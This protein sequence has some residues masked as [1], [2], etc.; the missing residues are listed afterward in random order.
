[1]SNPAVQT[2][3]S[4]PDPSDAP[5]NLIQL[6]QLQNR[7]L[8]SE[9]LGDYTPYVIQNGEPGVA[10]HDKVWFELDA[11]GR[12]V[13]I[14]IQWH[15]SWRRIYN[16][17]MGEIRGYTGNPGNDFDATGWGKPTE[18]YDGWHLCNGNDGAPDYS[19]HFLIGGHMNNEDHSGYIDNEWVT[20]IGKK[21]GMHTGGDI[22]F[23]LTEDTTWRQVIQGEPIDHW[24]DDT[25]TRDPVL[26]KL[27]G[28]PDD[29]HDFLI[30]A[31][32]GNTDPSPVTLIPPF[33]ALGWVTFLGYRT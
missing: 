20:W 7:H 18:E 8:H 17:M 14:K 3:L 6:F 31:D 22:E 24:R 19:D 5:L 1:M 16:G 21:T 33:I 12:P 4:M 9:I 23:T 26:G 29:S 10:D 11:Q 32:P 15:G 25:A 27:Y 30:G 2:Q 13:A 28:K